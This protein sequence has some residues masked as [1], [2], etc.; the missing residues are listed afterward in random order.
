MAQICSTTAVRWDASVPN[1]LVPIYTRGRMEASV[2][3]YWNQ[4]K[5]RIFPITLWELKALFTSTGKV[6]LQVC[7]ITNP[8]NVMANWLPFD[9]NNTSNLPDAPED[10]YYYFVL[11]RTYFDGSFKLYEADYDFTWGMSYTVAAAA[12][13]LCVICARIGINDNGEYC[14]FF[15]IGR[16]TLLGNGG[17]DGG[18]AGGLKVPS[19]P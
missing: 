6:A 15:N 1:P 18:A 4:I 7:N 12:H 19:N 10:S 11:D 2:D 8:E 16:I 14:V 17:G 13:S 9:P 3:K 5:E